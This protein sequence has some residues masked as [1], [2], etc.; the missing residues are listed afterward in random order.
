MAGST[1]IY[2]VLASK[3]VLLALEAFE[4]GHLGGHFFARSVCCGTNALNLE[5]EFIRVGRAEQGFFDG[6]ELFAVK[7]EER[8]IEGLHAVL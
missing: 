2:A 8:L 4:V 1:R 3:S 6:D 5:A 7:V